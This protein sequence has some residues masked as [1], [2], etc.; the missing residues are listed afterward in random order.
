MA[1]RERSKVSGLGFGLRFS[2][3]FSLVGISGSAI[4]L[5]VRFSIGV[6]C[7]CKHEGL[8]RKLWSGVQ[9]SG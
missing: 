4:S 3:R 8:D 6:R 7:R 2:L 9:G 1:S 5:E